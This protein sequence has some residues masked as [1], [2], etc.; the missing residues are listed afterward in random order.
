MMRDHHRCEISIDVPG[1]L[2]RHIV[3]HLDHCGLVL[4]PERSFVAGR[5]W[6]RGRVSFVR[7]HMRRKDKRE[8][9]ARAETFGLPFY[10]DNLQDGTYTI[11]LELVG[12]DGAVLPGTWNSTTRQIKLDH[13][14]QADPMPGMTMPAADGGAH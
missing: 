4:L 12:A 7:Q 10:L 14:A 5:R 11:K 6:L 3:H 1:R 2:D 9:T 8:K 13:T